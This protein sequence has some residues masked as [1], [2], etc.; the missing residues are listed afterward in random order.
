M[1]TDKYRNYIK[2]LTSIS[3]MYE[4]ATKRSDGW[5]YD[6]EAHGILARAESAIRKICSNPSPYMKR[7]A[8]ILD[9]TV[10]EHVKADRLVGIVKALKGDLEDGYLET[11]P[12]LVRGEMFENLIEMAR[13]LLE[14]GY[15]DAAAV[16]TGSSLESHL[17]QLCPKHGV[18]INHTVPDG[19]IKHKKAEQLNQILRKEGIYTL[20]DQKQITAWL[21]LRNNAAHG[22]YSA[23]DEQSVAS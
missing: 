21:D 11:F 12:E 10:S 5:V 18:P 20:F 3:E 7:M 16:I 2:H 1:P 13:H 8:K 23:Y 14:E 9:S 4:T 6:A 15:K 17:H 22:K 19:T